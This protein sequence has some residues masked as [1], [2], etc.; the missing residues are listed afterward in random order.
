MADR[1]LTFCFGLML[2]LAMGSIPVHA[3]DA[4]PVIDDTKI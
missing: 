3:Q 1:A 2:G 4:R